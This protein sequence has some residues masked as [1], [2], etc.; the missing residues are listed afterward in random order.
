[1]AIWGA[2]HFSVGEA[3]LFDSPWGGTSQRRALK[4]LCEAGSYVQ[5][6]FALMSE[7]TQKKSA[8]VRRLTEVDSKVFLW[9]NNMHRANCPLHLH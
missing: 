2:Q 5:T 1:M 3:A 9:I 4:S 7:D 6:L 8:S